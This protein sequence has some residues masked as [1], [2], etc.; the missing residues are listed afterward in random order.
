MLDMNQYRTNPGR[1]AALRSCIEHPAF[2]EAIEAI[3]NTNKTTEAMTIAAHIDSPNDKIEGRLLNQ[4]LGRESILRDLAVC[5]VPLDPPQPEQRA[6]YGAEEAMDALS[7]P[8]APADPWQ[9]IP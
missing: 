9:P 2:L 5:A 3:S 6:A 7:A 4:Q 8:D 1:C